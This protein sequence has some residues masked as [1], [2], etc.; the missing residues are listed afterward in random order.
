M[1]LHAWKVHS[2]AL[3]KVLKFF[4]QIQVVFVQHAR[5]L[6]DLLLDLLLLRLVFIC[7]RL[8]AGVWI[9]RFCA[10]LQFLLV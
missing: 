8:F 9:T 2:F 6:P 3:A 4:V 10:P 5:L 7:Y 1:C